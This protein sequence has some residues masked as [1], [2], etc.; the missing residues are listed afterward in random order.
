[1]QSLIR[2]LLLFVAFTLLVRQSNAQTSSNLK[3]SSE[4]PVAYLD[5]SKIQ[6]FMLPSFHINGKT[7]KAHTQGLLVHKTDYLSQRAGTT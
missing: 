2:T 3:T 1:M 4:V 5:T 7:A 6:I